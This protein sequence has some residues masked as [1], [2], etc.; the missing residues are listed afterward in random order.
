MLAPHEL[1][2]RD[3]T[4]SLRGYS[5]EEVDEHISFIIEKYTELYR[6]N[7][8]LEKKL[9][10]TEAQLDS[11]KAEEDSI[12]SALINAQ[13]ASKTIIDEANEQADVIMRSAKTNCDRMIRE[14]RET[15]SLEEEKLEAIKAEVN[16]F[17]AALYSAYTEHIGMIEA[18]SPQ[19]ENVET[20]R[21]RVEK[22]TS[23]VISRIKKDLEKL[24][25][26]ITGKESLYE[27]EDDKAD[28]DA[29]DDASTPAE[30]IIPD[31]IDEPIKPRGASVRD[32]DQLVFDDV[33]EAVVPADQPAPGETESGDDSVKND[34]IVDTI[35]KLN[36]EVNKNTRDDDEEF[37]KLL[38]M[39]S[40]NG[41]MTST[42]AF[43]IAYD[44]NRKD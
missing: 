13:K 44:G 11:V 10:L 1:K 39:A 3:F 15:V 4:K 32:A 20:S 38:R 27:S 30:I 24:D 36:S 12:R 16:A 29:E 19:D 21:E 2:K 8:A 22:L 33:D 37:L 43:E 5:T 41:E 14:L 7:D 26:V 17:K 23:S 28:V 18:I 6:E 31:K 42:E 34:S 40:G 25:P 9:H 35:K